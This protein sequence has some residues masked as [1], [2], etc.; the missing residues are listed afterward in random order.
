M[1][2]QNEK[3]KDTSEK[4]R[5]VKPFT[6]GTRLY[7]KDEICSFSAGARVKYASNLEKIKQIAAK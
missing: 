3:P 4:M 5:V 6:H 7:A 2:K 1:A